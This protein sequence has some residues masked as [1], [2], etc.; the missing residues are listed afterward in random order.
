MI[1][2]SPSFQVV[3]RKEKLEIP[4]KNS[5]NDTTSIEHDV[6]GPRSPILNHRI[7]IVFTAS[8]RRI[9][10]H[11]QQLEGETCSSPARRCSGSL[12][13]LR[14]RVKI[15]KNLQISIHWINMK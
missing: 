10:A 12:S 2:P 11:F 4:L 13:R 8:F 9:A 3:P 1:I 7:R 15:F 6:V 14:Q 5:F